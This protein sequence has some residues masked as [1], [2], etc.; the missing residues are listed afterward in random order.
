MNYE[1]FKTAVT[2]SVQEYF[3]ENAIITLHPIV[4]NNHVIL[5]GL[6]IQEKTVNISP[7]IYLN[8]YYEDYRCGK[9]ITDIRDEILHAYQSS[10]TTENMDLTFFTDFEKVKH[11]IVYKLIHFEKNK[12]QLNDIPYFPYLDF[13]I[14]FCCLILNAPNGNATILIHNHHLDY[15]HTTAEQIFSYAK[16]NT[17]TLLPAEVKSMEDVL[18]TFCQEIPI[19]TDVDTETLSI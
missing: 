6:T 12:E 15:W 9:S 2:A 19:F 13:A 10:R 3:G 5:D 11:R 18:K 1:N 17:P 8:Y 7:T 14:V 4:K 16:K